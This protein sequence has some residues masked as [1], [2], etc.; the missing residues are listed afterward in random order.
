ML[1]Q[2]YDDDEPGS[3]WRFI[4]YLDQSADDRQREPLT[5]IFLGRL[6]GTPAKQFPWAFKPSELLDV[7]SVPIEIDH[8][9]NRG[10]F[11]ARD[12]APS[13]SRPGS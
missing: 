6:G 10:W 1:A 2:Q 7:R 8:T 3:P 11:R 12:E 4:L 5:E 9:A 13:D